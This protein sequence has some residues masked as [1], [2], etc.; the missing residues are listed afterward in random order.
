MH[1]ANGL[2]GGPAGE[3]LPPAVLWR[4]I[5]TTATDTNPREPAPKMSKEKDPL[6]RARLEKLERWRDTWNIT[7]Y[8]HRVDGIIPLAEARSR[9]D[10]VAHDELTAAQEAGE[11]TPTD[12]RP[13]VVVSGRCV[14]RKP[15][16]QRWLR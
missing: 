6:V 14:Q 2:T 11:E 5:M 1:E 9:F 13:A 8:G 7:G 3:R 12:D 10:Q 15:S 16:M 4:A